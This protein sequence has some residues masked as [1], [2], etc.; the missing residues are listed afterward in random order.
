M[1]RS[2][3]SGAGRKCALALAVSAWWFV[4]WSSNGHGVYF[5][6]SHGPFATFDKCERMR[7]AINIDTYSHQNVIVGVCVD[8]DSPARQ[9][10]R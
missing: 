5:P 4:T 7:K 9:S 10:L 1:A 2:S 8:D 6:V 3:R